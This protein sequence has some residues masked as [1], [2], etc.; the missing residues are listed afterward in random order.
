MI[1][2]L[3][4]SLVAIVAAP[5]FGSIGWLIVRRVT[6]ARQTEETERLLA[7]VELVAKLKDAGLSMEEAR[8]LVAELGQGGTPQLPKQVTQVDESNSE[9]VAYQNTIAMKIRIS[10]RQDSLNAQLTEAAV[11]LGLLLQDEES[12]LAVEAQAAWQEY[13]HRE[14]A[15]AASLAAGG[16]AEGLFYLA[17]AVDLTTARIEQVKEQTRERLLL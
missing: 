15:F 12:K 2:D 8:K 5:I 1:G 14:S 10:A 9:P 13:C 4:L 6:R 7:G 11:D 16:T 17:T 3:P